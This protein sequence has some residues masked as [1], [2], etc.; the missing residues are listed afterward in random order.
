[1]FYSGSAQTDFYTWG[2]LITMK[3]KCMFF[4]H[5]IRLELQRSVFF[6][7]FGTVF[8]Y[9]DVVEQTGFTSRCLSFC[10]VRMSL[11]LTDLQQRIFFL[12]LAV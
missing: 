5:T 3:K 8:F 11:I 7:H 2:K 6:M 9:E 10:I 1:M 12:F 4:E